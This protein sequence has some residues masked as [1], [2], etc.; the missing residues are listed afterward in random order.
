MARVTTL[1]STEAVSTYNTFPNNSFDPR[2]IVDGVGT[3]AKLDRPTSITVHPNGSMLFFQEASNNA[4]RSLDLKTRRIRTLAGGVLRDYRDGV[5][6]AAS[7]SRMLPNNGDSMARDI[8]ENSNIMDSY[9]MGLAVSRDGGALYVADGGN[10]RLRKI[11]LATAKVTTVAGSGRALW[12]QADQHPRDGIG[13]AADFFL[14][15]GLALSHEGGLLFVADAF[16]EKIRQLD[17]SSGAVTTLAGNSYDGF[18]DGVGTNA[19][20]Y[21]PVYLSVS[22]DDATLFVSDVYNSAVRALNLTSGVVRTAASRGSDA[23]RTRCIQT[24][25][26]V[27][28]VECPYGLAKAPDDSRLYFAEPINNRI[29]QMEVGSGVVTSI[30]GWSASIMRG[31]GFADGIGS[32]AL[33]HEPLA[34]AVS[35]DGHTLYVADTANSAIRQIE[36]P[37]DAT[38]TLPTPALPAVAWAA[39]AAVL[40]LAG[41]V[42]LARCGWRRRR[43]RADGLLL[44]T[45][46]SVSLP[47]VQAW[48]QL[49]RRS[50]RSSSRQ[51]LHEQSGARPEG[52]GWASIGA[53]PSVS[54]CGSAHAPSSAPPE[55]H[56]VLETSDFSTLT[57]LS[58]IGRGGFATVWIARW[59]G[60]DLAVKVLK[61][62]HESFD[63]P[64]VAHEVAILRR[65]RHPCICALFG[66]M[67]FEQ[68][69]ALVLEYMAGGSLSSYLFERNREADPTPFRPTPRRE[70][71]ARGRP[72]L[73]EAWRRL[74]DSMTLTSAS[75][76]AAEPLAEPRARLSDEL[77]PPPPPHLAQMLPCDKKIGF[78][79]QLASGLC[80]LHSHGILH[81]D[82]KTD[83]ALLDVAHSSC[84]LAD[85]GLASLSL[86]SP[87]HSNVRAPSTALLFHSAALLLFHSA[88][89]PQRCFPTERCFSTELL[90]HSGRVRPGCHLAAAFPQRTRTR[91][92]APRLSPRSCPLPC[93]SFTGRQRRRHHALRR[94]REGPLLV[95]A[96]QG[97]RRAQREQP[98]QRQPHRRR[99]ATARARGPRRRLRLR[100]AALGDCARAPRLRGPLG[101]SGPH[102]CVPRRA[103]ADLAAAHAR[104]HRSPHAR[105]LGAVP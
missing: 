70:T 89:L 94:S 45:S 56:K 22:S 19:E 95:P 93:L 99:P 85:F 50:G 17:L 91:T 101:S 75:A 102:G 5:G 32:S 34:L 16:D 98:R 48:S 39:P 87:G 105:L 20:F 58:P 9:Q 37:P 81:C 46:F 96:P 28:I 33:F 90:S 59:Q 1:V 27:R 52:P 100:A 14:P 77:L 65:L 72:A 8:D 4:I 71:S 68:R 69:P 80:F 30:A 54:S 40:V 21:L 15:S 31:G 61:V 38:L 60:N 42:V 55:S 76:A 79:V 24:D 2:G 43:K 64:E 13:T 49:E 3:S 11:D 103:A 78:G 82:V 104:R 47:R 18:A 62:A 97:R 51:P 7:F 53:A 44:D 86:K 74:T 10:C 66:L 83:N 92:R 35:P 84:K 36:L 88:A 29:V 6:T 26:C 67:R 73:G 41:L 63:A 12:D 23:T 57:M 25:V